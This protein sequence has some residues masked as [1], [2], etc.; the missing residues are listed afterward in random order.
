MQQPKCKS[1]QNS[2]FEIKDPALEK[3]ECFV[4]KVVFNNRNVVFLSYYNAP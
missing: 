2:Y 4:I 1:K 3:I